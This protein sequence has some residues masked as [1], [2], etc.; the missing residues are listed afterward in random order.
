MTS[1]IERNQSIFVGNWEKE[2]LEDGKVK[3]T[4][5]VEIGDREYTI[6]ARYS[7]KL[8]QYLENPE[9]P[10][11]ETVKKIMEESEQQIAKLIE[12]FKEEPAK[13]EKV[14]VKTDIQKR[15]GSVAIKT[16][17][18]E[19]E[20]LTLP[21]LK[22]RNLSMGNATDSLIQKVA[23][24]AMAKRIQPK[25]PEIRFVEQKSTP[26]APFKDKAGKQLEEILRV[27]DVKEDVKVDSHGVKKHKR[28][29]YQGQPVEVKEFGE[30]AYNGPVMED[31]RRRQLLIMK[32]AWAFIMENAENIEDIESVSKSL[33]YL[34]VEFQKALQEPEY[35]LDYA[36]MKTGIDA[37][38]HLED[39]NKK[40]VELIAQFARNA[41][42]IINSSLTT[43]EC[44]ISD[45]DRLEREQVLN[46]GRPIVVNIFT[47]NGKK[48][49]SMQTP[50]TRDEKGKK[51]ST[52]PSTL[53][54]RE[55]LANYVSTTSGMISDQGDVT[56]QHYAIRHSSYTPIAVS[57][58]ILRQGI[59]IQNVKQLM[60]DLAETLREG[61]GGGD[62]PENPITIPLRSMIL[63]TPLVGDH[64][65]NK[66]KFVAGSWTGESEVLQLKESALALS[67]MRG[68]AV[69]LRIKGETVWVK[70][71]S[72][73][74]NLG[75]NKEAARIG[76]MGKLPISSF[77][78]EINQRGYFQFLRD[79]DD[80][81]L[82]QDLPSNVLSLFREVRKLE[83]R[84][85]AY[86]TTVKEL[87]KLIA[88][89]KEELEVKNR[90]LE[91]LY[92]Q[93]TKTRDPQLKKQIKTLRKEVREIESTINKKFRE[94]YQLRL[95]AV[96][97]NGDKIQCFQKQ[98]LEEME[99][100]IAQTSDMMK[101]EELILVRDIFSNYFQ[102]KE[103][104]ESKAYRQAESVMDFQTLYIQTYEMID[105]LVEFFCKS[106]EDRT[107][108]VDNKLQERVVF[109]ALHQKQATRVEKDR[110][111]ID[112]LIAPAVHQYSTSRDNTLWNSDSPG[113]QITPEVNPAVPAKI[114]RLQATMAKRVMQKARSLDHTDVLIAA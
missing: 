71:D 41:Q 64:L 81:L 82:K 104:F 24:R 69:P 91:E 70:L 32:A 40:Q 110:Q 54:E 16:I 96:H 26:L 56:V 13:I 27:I 20:H 102:A 45:L 107:G 66:S 8:A 53:R 49:F 6:T 31:Y 84:S 62:T 61:Q 93:Y 47:I 89:H 90:R 108:R 43:G 44:K 109:S 51:G 36:V 97:R 30:G 21:V 106:A 99:N 19:E 103:L 98:I 9:L 79:V 114:D 10:V 4:R 2:V 75:A 76:A 94:L 38:A 57:D 28:F 78:S 52:I 46:R 33:S 23:E 68:R 67:T 105:Y 63:L 59:A 74:M 48:F 50:E 80:H 35:Q 7:T 88:D 25:T 12:S 85:F 22:E 113:L 65:R 77:E 83:R 72:S 37:T 100:E 39:I 29:D 87:N 58:T 55:G 11:D 5:S 14:T 18:K 111:E 42:H 34:D 1:G 112:G 101:K 92:T 86:V 3:L 15:T 95:N 73:Y 17:G 60:G